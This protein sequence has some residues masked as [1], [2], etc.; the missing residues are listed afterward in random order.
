MKN[1]S[2]VTRALA[3]IAFGAAIFTCIGAVYNQFSPGG[4]LS[5]TW[6]SQ[7]VNV[8][9]GSPFIT[10]TLPAGN[11]GTGSAFTQFSGP[12]TTV[13]TLTLPNANATLLSDANAVT[14]A[15]GGTGLASAADD[16]TLISSGSAWAATAVPSCANDGAHALVYDTSTNS[17]ACSTL[18][19]GTTG[20]FTAT[21]TTGC[22]VN[23]TVTISYAIAGS[24]V[25]VAPQA[26]G[27]CATSNSTQFST[28]TGDMPV[29]IRPARNVVIPFISVVNNGAPVPGCI[30][31][32]TSGQIVLD[33]LTAATMA[34]NNA[35]WTAASTKSVFNQFQGAY[36][37][38]LN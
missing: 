11:G 35:G 16:T 19:G 29:A 3:A 22:T 9:A 20:T 6:N 10:G 26:A 32:R 18:T 5:G 24:V 7:N 14:F 1:L 31:F 38:P 30:E 36:S 8:A 17:F 15:Q 12:N 25:S 4:A 27:N 33:I 2:P 37:Y 34:C 21:F 23:P 28:S 13:K